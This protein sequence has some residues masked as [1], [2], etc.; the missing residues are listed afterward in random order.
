M[1]CHSERKLTK[2]VSH[3]K[4]IIL[5]LTKS[6]LAT[7]PHLRNVRCLRQEQTITDNNNTNT[8]WWS[9]ERRRLFDRAMM[10]P[11]SGRLDFWC[12]RVCSTILCPIWLVNCL[13]WFA[14][15]PNVSTR[16]GSGRDASRV[17]YVPHTASKSNNL[18]TYTWFGD[19]SLAAK[20]KPEFLFWSNGTHVGHLIYI[21]NK[22]AKILFSKCFVVLCFLMYV[23]F[24]VCSDL[25]SLEKDKEW[26]HRHPADR[27]L[28]F[29]QNVSVQPVAVQRGPRN[30]QLG[31]DQHR[32]IVHRT[33]LCATQ[34]ST[35]KRGNG[36]AEED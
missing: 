36:C 11:N 10:C 5:G 3:T 24:V 21:L 7:P 28:W 12:A 15:W 8:C 34:Q 33:G 29:G 26:P 23:Y 18:K 19:F 27:P 14:N 30:V 22:F 17:D 32:R 16:L 25:H 20:E 31:H 13:C 9:D 1:V 4:S 35:K 2:P 6:G